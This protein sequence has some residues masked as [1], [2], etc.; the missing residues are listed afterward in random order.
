MRIHEDRAGASCTDGGTPKA[1]NLQSSS[2]HGS[3]HA[4][5]LLMQP[6]QKA[7]HVCHMKDKS[8]IEQKRDVHMAF[9]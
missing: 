6:H 1:S 7:S 2:L 9:Q 5:K 3:P 8:E 4:K